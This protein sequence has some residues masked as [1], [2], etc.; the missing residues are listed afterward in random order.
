MCVTSAED[1]SKAEKR[2]EVVQM[3]MA[4]DK[5]PWSQAVSLSMDNTNSMIGAHNSFASCCK[6]KIQTFLCMDVPVTWHILLQ[7][8]QMMLLQQ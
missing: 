3:K 2:F 5:I 6:K 8:M 7:A 1:A 4:E